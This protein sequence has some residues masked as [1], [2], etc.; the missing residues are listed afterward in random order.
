MVLPYWQMSPNRSGFGTETRRPKPGGKP[1][2]HT[3]DA[4]RVLLV[5]ESR[6]ADELQ[7]LVAAEGIIVEGCHPADA[8]AFAARFGPA[9]VLIDGDLPSM[10]RSTLPRQ[11]RADHGC[12][13]VLLLPT[14]SGAAV[15]AALQTDADTVM[16]WPVDLV[17]LRRVLGQ[18]ILSGNPTG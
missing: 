10:V 11:L 3:D 18:R 6:H 13:C 4:R 16:E 2:T 1:S 12:P 17:S 15:T 8:T 7:V 14:A 9:L 5:S